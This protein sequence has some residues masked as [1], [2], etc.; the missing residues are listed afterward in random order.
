MTLPDPEHHPEVYQ[1][2]IAKR[3][4]AWVVD[5]LVIIAL[6]TIVV[7]ATVLVGL[8]FLP[9]IAV[10]VSI[11]Y[12]WVMLTH[13]GAT[14]GMMLAAVRLRHLD[15]RA[16]GPVVAFWHAAIFSLGMFFVVPQLISIGLMFTTAYR[17]GLNDVILGTTVINRWVTH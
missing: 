10:G 15:D 11:T 14:L 17:Q 6:V 3:F 13:Y 2:L 9:V 1:D 16:P 4:L 5:A 8:F 7:L 12:R